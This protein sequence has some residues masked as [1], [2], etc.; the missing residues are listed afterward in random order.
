M[1]DKDV[2]FGLIVGLIIGFFWGWFITYA[3]HKLKEVIEEHEQERKELLRFREEEC[4]KNLKIS[5]SGEVIEKKKKR[6]ERC[7]SR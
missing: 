4:I 6:R 1:N 2:A 5:S 7:Q 3:N